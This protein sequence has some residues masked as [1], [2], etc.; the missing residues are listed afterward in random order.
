MPTSQLDSVPN[1]PHDHLDTPENTV[2]RLGFADTARVLA[3][4]VAPTLATGVIKRRPRLMR[5]TERLGLDRVAITTMR[6]LRARLGPAPVALR[7]PGR[8]FVFPL[9]E[10]DAGRVLAGT[11]DPF[12]PA[13]V[14][15]RAA[16]RHF[17]PHAVLVSTGAERTD[18]RRFT[19]QVLLP[20]HALHPLAPHIVGIVLEETAALLRN[21]KLTWDEFNRHW[22]AAVRRIVLGER[23]RHDDELTDLLGTLRAAGNWAYL[24]PRRRGDRRK[25]LTEV[26]TYV[27]AAEPNSLAALVHATPHAGDVDPAGQ[28]PHWLFAFDAAGMATFRALALL[29]RHPDKTSSAR[30]DLEGLDLTQPRQLPY[31][32]ACVLDTVR[33]WPTTPALLRETTRDTAWGVSGTTTFLYT[34]FFHRDPDTLPGADRFTPEIWLDGTAASH[35]AL[36]PFSAGPGQCPGRN[37]VLLSTST[38]LARVL[39]GHDVTLLDKPAI[40][41]NRPLPA[42]LDNFSTRLRVTPTTGRR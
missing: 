27:R 15:K 16:L 42:T 5:L 30:E 24:H 20:E 32:R 1:L 21:E 3:K 25:F 28:V 12:S 35:P 37:V 31:L 8:S 23:A 29:A 22:W 2:R 34:P 14:E 36:T 41:P 39:A 40:D 19:E 6:G 18:R 7:L 38:M 9:S 10:M 26:A 11:P 13:T 4:V 17:Q 33:L